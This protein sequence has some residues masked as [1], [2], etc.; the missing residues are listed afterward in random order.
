MWMLTFALRWRAL[1]RRYANAL[2]ITS[3][4]SVVYFTDSQTIPVVPNFG[5]AKQPWWDTFESFLLGV[6]SVRGAVLAQCGP[7]P[8]LAWGA[9]RGG[10]RVCGRGRRSSSA[11]ER[12]GYAALGSSRAWRQRG[13]C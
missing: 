8:R 5:K 4:G 2:D 11:R 10:V 12:L 9:V 7:A 3:D 13:A 6:Y 1:G